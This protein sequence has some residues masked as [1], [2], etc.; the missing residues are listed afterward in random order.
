VTQRSIWLPR[1]NAVVLAWLVVTALCVAGVDRWDLP[2]WLPVHALLLGA[3][4]TA[5]LVWSEHFAVAVLHAQQP[6]RGA[7]SARLAALSA[8]AVAVLAG[9]MAG[10]VWLLAAGAVITAG[11][12]AWH[13][14]ALRRMSRRGFGGILAGIVRYYHAVPA[15]GRH[16]A[17]ITLA[18]F[19]PIQV[20]TG[21][22]L[23]TH[24][25]VTWDS[26]AEPSYGCTLA[27]KLALVL[28]AM[29][30]A[31]G[32]G[33]AAAKGGTCS[34]VRRRSAPWSAP[35]APCCWRPRSADSHPQLAHFQ[36]AR[37]PSACRSQK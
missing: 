16:F 18:V 24:A 35:S 29:V 12:V 36:T 3:V 26:L 10:L 22:A 7:A 25:G 11:A 21:M 9:R 32:H 33:I 15:A 8:G 23:A 4:S 34:P 37:K 28:A 5:I 14:L 31:A 13:L 30:A 20:A 6:A 19:L 27:A 17:R 1:A 2:V